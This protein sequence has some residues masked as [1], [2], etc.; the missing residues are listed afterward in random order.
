M[1]G[2]QTCAL[3]ISAHILDVGENIF[4]IIVRWGEELKIT[5]GM[6]FSVGH[7]MKEGQCSLYLN[8]LL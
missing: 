2:V 7:I 8:F 6:N 1:T 3:P 4:T 5:K